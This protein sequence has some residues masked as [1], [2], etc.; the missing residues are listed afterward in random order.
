MKSAQQGFTLIELLIVVAIIGILATFA[1][2]AYSDYV[3]KAK[4]GAA[5]AEISPGKTG[6]EVMVN[7][8]NTANITPAAI[9]LQTTT[10]NCD[11]TTTQVAASN[12]GTIACAIK[13]N[14]AA[15]GSVTW[16]RDTAGAWTCK[17]SGDAKYASKGCPKG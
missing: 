14:L 11:I 5:I 1:I 10:P 3:A 9:G 7:E 6:F 12:T 4:V 17:Y 13:D 2:P 15:T 8:G 16:T